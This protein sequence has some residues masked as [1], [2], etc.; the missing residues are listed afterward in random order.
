M[1]QYMLRWKS[2]SIGKKKELGLGNFWN[3]CNVWP[4][5][6]V[7]MEN[8]KVAEEIILTKC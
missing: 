3:R 2:L 1:P 5:E 8:I 7:N 4:L 6:K